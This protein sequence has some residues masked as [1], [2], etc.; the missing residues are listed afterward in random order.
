MRLSRF[1]PVGFEAALVEE[2]GDGCSS[3]TGEQVGGAG[4]V[5]V[6]RKGRGTPDG[7]GRHRRRNLG[8]DYAGCRDT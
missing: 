5:A 8:R 6:G 2:P 3:G 4:E 7:S 1:D